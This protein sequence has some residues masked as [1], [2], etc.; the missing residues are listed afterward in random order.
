MNIKENLSLIDPNAFLFNLTT[1]IGL[2]P[3]LEQEP[4]IDP[5]L[6]NDIPLFNTI[7]EAELYFLSEE[8]HYGYEFYRGMRIL[9]IGRAHV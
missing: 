2:N 6:T 5:G 7:L 1:T 4:V 3:S 9:Q 8:D